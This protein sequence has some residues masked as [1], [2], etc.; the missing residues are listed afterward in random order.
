[1]PGRNIIARI[2]AHYFAAAGT[3]AT[4]AY[5]SL[6][7]GTKASNANVHNCRP[8]AAPGAVMA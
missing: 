1:L 5:Y 6:W 8:Q 7:R 4:D 3:E 2:E